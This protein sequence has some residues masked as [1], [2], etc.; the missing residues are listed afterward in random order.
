VQSRSWSYARRA[1]L[2][3]AGVL[4]LAQKQRQVSGSRAVHGANCAL[5]IAELCE[6]EEL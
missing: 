3:L 4:A 5:R 1:A 6:R 2:D